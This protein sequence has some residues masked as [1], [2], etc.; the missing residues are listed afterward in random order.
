MKIALERLLGGPC[1]HMFEMLAVRNG[2]TSIFRPTRAA[3]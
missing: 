2:N 3:W 1:H